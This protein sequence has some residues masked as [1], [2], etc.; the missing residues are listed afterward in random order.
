MLIV[1]ASLGFPLAIAL[2]WLFELRTERPH[3]TS[4]RLQR[5]GMGAVVIVGATLVAGCAR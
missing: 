5:I 2:S 4:Y 3:Q 1:L